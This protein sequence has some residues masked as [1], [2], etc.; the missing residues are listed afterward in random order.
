MSSNSV[1]KTLVFSSPYKKALLE[2]MLKDV[3]IADRCS[4][5]SALEKTLEAA[6]FPSNPSAK[7]WVE[8]LYDGGTLGKAFEDCFGYIAGGINWGVAASNT[9][10]MVRFFAQLVAK[11][12]CSLDPSANEIHYL[13]SQWDT[14]VSLI[15]EDS[16]C[17][18][19][20][21]YDILSADSVTIESSEY[22][23]CILDHWAEL[24]QHTR[25]FR[26]LCV[27]ARV[28]N[29]KLSSVDTAFT[30]REYCRILQEMTKSWH[31]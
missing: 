27:I 30:R 11:V 9:Q 21:L 26:F 10:E 31:R 5:S 1:K 20:K 25:T 24:H 17:Y 23:N 15:P 2:S 7:M 29:K 6:L 14:I 22:V 28:L 13:K 4:E 18:A 12:D 19:A 16:Q 3:A 8:L